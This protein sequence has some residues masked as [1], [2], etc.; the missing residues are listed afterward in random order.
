MDAKERKYLAACASCLSHDVR[1][2]CNIISYHCLNKFNP[3]S[4]RFNDDL[5]VVYK[6]LDLLL[7]DIDDYLFNNCYNERLDK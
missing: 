1:T 5:R 3:F 4:V 2:A 7:R 6:S